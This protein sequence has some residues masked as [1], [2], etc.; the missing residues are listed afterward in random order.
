MAS[1][2]NLLE[3][4]LQAPK[5]SCWRQVHG[6]LLLDKHCDISSN[7]ALQRAK[8]MYRATKAGH[9]GTLDPLATGLLVICF[10]EATKF[11]R[12][13]IDADKVYRATIKLGIATTT[14]DGE[15]DIVSQKNLSFNPAQVQGILE[16][17]KGK[18]WQTPPMYS[19]LKYDGKPL[20][21]YARAGIE[22]ARVAREV[23]VYEI[24]LE[25]FHDNEVKLL[26]R[27]SKGTYI[28]TLA[29]DLGRKLGCGAYL[30]SLIRVAIG[31]FELAN[32]VKLCD[33]EKMGDDK[34]DARL[35][36]LDFGA[37][38]LP[39]LELNKVALMR[40]VNGVTVEIEPS[41]STGQ[42]RLYD[43]DNKFWGIGKVDQ[44]RLTP[45][46]MIA[47]LF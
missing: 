11:S 7:A 25:S 26:I 15:G 17:L 31:N 21:S 36:S 42:V 32:A 24:D 29:E 37:H 34:K 10:G 13:L 27:C 46:R 5:R 9:T 18:I 20:Y 12:F 33:L 44:G 16:T 43:P 38:G 8:R 30:K 2:I 19:A 3:D 14:G 35:L 23:T 6:V 47:N 4:G 40:L 39:E 22:I 28:R 45:V 41:A 1:A